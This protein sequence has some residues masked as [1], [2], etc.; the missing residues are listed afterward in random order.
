MTAR[1][2]KVRLELNSL[3]KLVNLAAWGLDVAP[4]ARPLDDAALIDTVMG[5]LVPSVPVGR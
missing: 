5:R 1:T 4:E 2:D 3:E